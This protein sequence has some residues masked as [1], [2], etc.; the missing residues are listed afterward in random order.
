MIP[1]D[2]AGAYGEQTA[3]LPHGRKQKGKKGEHG[4][5]EHP[6]S[7]PG[8]WGHPG[9]MLVW[10]ALSDRRGKVVSQGTLLQQTP[11]WRGL[12]AERRMEMGFPE[13]PDMFSSQRG[14]LW[15]LGPVQDPCPGVPPL[16]RV[17]WGFGGGSSPFPW[18]CWEEDELLR[19]FAGG[20]R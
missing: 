7:H 1:L 3:F 4:E 9:G 13:L 16:A 15:L 10:T 12:L 11:G 14:F 18:S 17:C 20:G 5:C 2:S 8:L 19:S 6:R